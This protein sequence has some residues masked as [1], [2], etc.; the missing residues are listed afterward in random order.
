MLEVVS[1]R[2]LVA[3]NGGNRR[4]ST[5]AET[6]RVRVW[7]RQRAERGGER[8]ANEREG[9]GGTAS[10]W[11]VIHARA[12]AGRGARRRGGGHAAAAFWL[13]VEEKEING[14]FQNTPWRF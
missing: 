12:A 13:K 4:T 3:G 2:P 5:A 1:A 14:N 7:F 9:R 8:G 11:E 6:T 10:P